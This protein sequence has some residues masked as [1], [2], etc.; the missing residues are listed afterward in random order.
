[1]LGLGEKASSIKKGLDVQWRKSRKTTVQVCSTL[2]KCLFLC[3]LCHT[4]ACRH[5]VTLDKGDKIT[6][7]CTLTHLVGTTIAGGPAT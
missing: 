5:S 2:L 1:M 4:N 7:Y 3:C 6:K